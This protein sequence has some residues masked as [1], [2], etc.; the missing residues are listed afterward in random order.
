MSL[1]VLA[2]GA[3][4]PAWHVVLMSVL[5]FAGSAQFAAVSVLA[6]GGGAV[7]AVLAGALL[8][9]RY[10]ALG[11][12]AAPQLSPRRWVRILQAHLIIDESYG[13]AV[14]RGRGGVPDGPSLVWSGL[15]VWI[16][17]VT[18]TA[19]GAVAGDVIGDPTAL[20]LDAAFPALFVALMWPLLPGPG[21]LRAA[22]VGA[23]TALLLQP[24][25]PAGLPLAAAAVAVAVTARSPADSDDP[26][27]PRC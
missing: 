13:L 8:N 20:G 23:V 16:F 21:A 22:V 6:S 27:E 2:V 18:G 9:S 26:D 25:L 12:A 24:L 7:A 5:V 3:G 1:G 19:I 11:A 4:I 17:W 10:L 15:L 14:A